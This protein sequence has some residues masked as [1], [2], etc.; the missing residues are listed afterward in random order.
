M[1]HPTR[2][3][4]Y[5]PVFRAVGGCRARRGDAD[6]RR[7]G[8]RR[9]ADRHGPGVEHQ[10][11]QRDRQPAPRPPAPRRSRPGATAR[12]DPPGDG[13]RRDLRRRQRDRRHPPAVSRWTPRAV[14]ASQAAAVATAAHDVL[15]GLV[16]TSLPQVIA[17]LDALYATSLGKIPDGAAKNDGIAFGAAAAAAMLAN[18]LGDGRTGTRTF[19]IGTRRANGVSCRQEQRLLVDRRRPAVRAQAPSQLRVRGPPPLTSTTTWRSSTRSRRSAP[20]SAT[21]TPKEALANFIVVNPFGPVNRAFRELATAHGLSTAQ[22]ARLFAMTSMSSADALI[23]CWN[24]KDF[25]TSGGPRRRS[26]SGD[27]RQPDHGRRPRPGSRSSRR[28]AT[29]TSRPATTASR[30]R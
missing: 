11:A 5:T 30:P 12:G 29:P 7:L 2:P 8:L 1:T 3:S 28:P 4:R 20:R 13:P 27:R 6:P 25:Y 26:R 18:R 14:G 9:R 19:P 22:Q 10:R 16:P 23:G 15:V 17:S 24:N 21:R